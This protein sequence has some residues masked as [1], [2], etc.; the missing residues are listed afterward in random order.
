MIEKKRFKSSSATR[1]LLSHRSGWPKGFGGHQLICRPAIPIQDNPFELG[2]PPRRVFSK[3]L[4]NT[5]YEL[6]PNLT[7]TP[8]TLYLDGITYF[9]KIWVSGTRFLEGSFFKTPEGFWRVLRSTITY[10]LAPDFSFGYV[11]LNILCIQN[12]E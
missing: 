10:P 12:S 3:A 9:K 6:H 11:F 8:N 5:R 1:N 2:T 4:S 7:S